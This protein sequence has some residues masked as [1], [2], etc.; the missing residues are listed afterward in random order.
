MRTVQIINASSHVPDLFQFYQF[1]SS[2]PVL[3]KLF[4]RLQHLSCVTLVSE[5]AIQSPVAL[6][7]TRHYLIVNKIN[8]VKSVL[9]SYPRQDNAINNNRNNNTNN[10]FNSFL[11]SWQQSNKANYSQAPK[12]QYR[13]KNNIMKSK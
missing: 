8:M 2:N 9:R 12:Q 10:L 6:W 5:F 7:S 13:I 3:I 4:W 1:S 11:W